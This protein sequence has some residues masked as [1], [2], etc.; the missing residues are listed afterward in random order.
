MKSSPEYLFL[1][2]I[3]ANF[4]DDVAAEYDG[5]EGELLIFVINYLPH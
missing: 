2:W 4:E 5:N 1:F 3:L